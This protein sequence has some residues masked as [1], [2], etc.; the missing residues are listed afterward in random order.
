AERA[1][2]LGDGATIRYEKLLLATGARPRRLN[3]P[4]SDLDGL[5]YLRRA[6]DADAIRAALRRGRRA[7]MVGAG[8]IGM[9]VAAACAQRGLEV[10]VIERADRP[11]ATFASTALGNFLRRYYEDRGVRFIFGEEVASF[12]GDGRLAAVTTRQ[13]SR[14]EADFA[15]LG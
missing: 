14:V 3:L 6:E 12:E 1:V 4:G 15:V 8:Y 13:G 9:E 2:R 5:F 10:T 11:W 7:V